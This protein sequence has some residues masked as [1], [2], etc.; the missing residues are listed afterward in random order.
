[1]SHNI[2]ERNGTAM[3]NVQEFFCCSV[4]LGL[5]GCIVLYKI[6]FPKDH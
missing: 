2:R 1:M 3:W 4:A 5:I 6:C